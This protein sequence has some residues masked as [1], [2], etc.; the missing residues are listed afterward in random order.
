M[1]TK[2]QKNRQYTRVIHKYNIMLW[3][4]VQHWLLPYS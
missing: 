3:Y 2:K 4:L 1:K